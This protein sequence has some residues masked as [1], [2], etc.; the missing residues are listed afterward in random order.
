MSEDILKP[1]SVMT[2]DE[3]LSVLTVN[4]DNF[5]DEYKTKVADE[6]AKRGINLEEK[7]KTARYKLN[8]QD[9]EEVDVTAAYEKTSLLKNSLD[10]VYFINYMNEH[11][12]IQK[13]ENVFVI[14]HHTPKR[15]FSSFFLDNE[16]E[17]KNSLQNFFELNNWLPDDIEVIEHWE[18]FAESTSSDYILKLAQLMDESNISYCLNSDQNVRF[19]SFNSPYSIVLP[20]EELQEAQEIFEKMEQLKESLHKKLDEAESKEDIDLQLELLTELESVTPEDSLVYYN[21]AQ[22]L[23]EKG[24]YQNAS[25]ALIESFNIEMSD[26]AV[27]DI[28]DIENYLTSILDKVESKSNIL[29]CLA[30]IF[31]FKGDVENSLEYYIKIINLDEDDAMAHLQLGH[32]YYAHTDDDDKVKTHFNKYI[33]LEPESEE[34]ESIEEILNNL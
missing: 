25:D 1:I 17:L 20:V 19:N 34:R 9:V 22:L 2:N 6:I 21:K 26:G 32:H 11:Y 14:H 33:E 28:E 7:F 5:N 18:T 4:R 12:A 30:T 10:V 27:D 29:H 31:A 8:L 24:D 3:L 23:D 15:G 13:N 16:A